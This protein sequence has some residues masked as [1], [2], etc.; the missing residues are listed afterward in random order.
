MEK[1]DPS[2]VTVRL[3]VEPTHHAIELKPIESQRTIASSDSSDS[4]TSLTTA[5]TTTASFSSTA[6]PQPAPTPS[7]QNTTPTQTPPLPA[8]NLKKFKASSVSV[9]KKFLSQSTT[10]DGKLAKNQYSASPR[11]SSLTS[12]S[13][14]GTPGSA[15]RLLT[16]KIGLNNSILNSSGAP[17][18]GWARTALLT[19]APLSLT[20]SKSPELSHP[21]AP[22]LNPSHSIDSPPIRQDAHLTSKNP[23]NAF[24]HAHSTSPYPHTSSLKPLIPSSSSAAIP[25]PANATT[26]STTTAAAVPSSSSSPSPS[27]TVPATATMAIAVSS[28]SSSATSSTTIAA[29]SSPSLPSASP[30]VKL[31]NSMRGGINSLATDFPTAQEV[32]QHTKLK[33]QS[34]AAAVA[35]RDKVVQDRAAA[36]AAYNQQL[37]QTLDGFRGTHLDPNASHWDEMEDEDDMFGEVVEFG[38]GTQYKVTEVVAPA[39]DSG[40]SLGNETAPSSG[41]SQALN[42]KNRFPEDSRRTH[43]SSTE[44]TD[45][46]PPF[47]R[48]RAELK[49]L[50]N[51]RIGKFEPY[52]GKPNEKTRDNNHPQV[53]L[54]QRQRDEPN[55]TSSSTHYSNRL[56]HSTAPDIKSTDTKLIQ[57]HRLPTHQS[58]SNK[59]IPPSRTAL[60]QPLS[61]TTLPHTSAPSS[62]S[63]PIKPA[64]NTPQLVDGQPLD[65]DT[66]NQLLR[67]KKPDLDQVHRIEMTS[68]AERARKRRQE[69]EAA[70]ESEKERAKLKATE[71]EAKLKAAAEAARVA[72]EAAKAAQDAAKAAEKAASLDAKTKN[73]SK[74]DLSPKLLQRPSSL[75]QSRNSHPTRSDSKDS[76]RRP[77]SHQTENTRAPA[78]TSQK[79]IPPEAEAAVAKAKAATGPLTTTSEVSPN[80]LTTKISHPSDN[81]RP[82]APLPSQKEAFKRAAEDMS[83]RPL[84]WKSKMVSASASQ[85]KAEDGQSQPPPPPPPSDHPSKTITIQ[86]RS[87]PPTP[88]TEPRWR[89]AQVTTPNSVSRADARQLPTHIQSDLIKVPQSTPAPSAASPQSEARST[90]KPSSDSRASPSVPLP[91][92]G[93]PHPSAAFPRSL[94]ADKKAGFKLPEMSHLDTVM[95]RIKGVLEAD[96]EARAKASIVSTPLKQSVDSRPTSVSSL[97][98]P[99]DASIPASTK[100]RPDHQSQETPISATSL[101]GQTSSSPTAVY[102]AGRPHT[103]L[104]RQ[105]ETPTILNTSSESKVPSHSALPAPGSSSTPSG[106]PRIPNT[107]SLTP[108]LTNPA[109]KKASTVRKAARFDIPTSVE[110]KPS[111][112]STSTSYPTAAPKWVK[113]DPIVF[114]DATR[115]ERPLSPRPA[116]KAFSVKFGS[117]K[118]KPRLASHVIKSFWN[119]LAPT[120]VNVLSWDP[121]MPNLSPRTLSRDDLL[122]PKKYIR[123]IVVSHVQLPKNSISN[124]VFKAPS[125]PKAP[126]SE[127]ST[128]HDGSTRGGRGRGA[129]AVGSRGRGRGRA[130]ET[131]SWRRSVEQDKTS[132]EIDVSVPS[133]QAASSPTPTCPADSPQSTTAQ[134]DPAKAGES[135]P[136]RRTK[137]KIPDGLKVAFHKP[138]HLL[139][140]TATPSGMF[141]VN[142]EITGQDVPSSQDPAP[143]SSQRKSPSPNRSPTQTSI[144]APLTP[145]VV[146][147]PRSSSKPCMSGSKGST[148]PWNKSPLAFSVLDSHT[149]NVWSQPDGQITG[150]P[151]PIGKAENSLE[152]IADDFPATLPRTLNDFNAEEEPSSSTSHQPAQYSS[153]SAR[154][155]SELTGSGGKREPNG[156]SPHNLQLGSSNYSDDHQPKANGLSGQHQYTNSPGGP[157]QYNNDASSSSNSGHMYSHHGYSSP[158]NFQVPPGYQLVPIGSLQSTQPTQQYPSIAG[159]YPGQPAS[160]PWSPS[161]GPIQPNGYARS[162]QL[163]S[164]NTSYPSPL[165]SSSYPSHAHS[166]GLNTISDGPGFNK[167]P[168][169]IAPRGSR[170]SVPT[171]SHLVNRQP[172][173]LSNF[174]PNSHPRNHPHYAPSSAKAQ[175]APGHNYHPSASSLDGP[176]SQHPSVSNTPTPAGGAGP[177]SYVDGSF[178]PFHPAAGL[179]PLVHLPPPTSFNQGAHHA[180]GAGGQANHLVG[181]HHPHHPHA[182]STLMGGPP[183][184]HYMAHGH[185]F[186]PSHGH[187]P[188]PPGSVPHGAGNGGLR[189]PGTADLLH[190]GL[191]YPQPANAAPAPP[192]HPHLH[193]HHSQGP[194]GF[195]QPPRPFHSHPAAS[196]NSGRTPAAN[197]GP[198]QPNAPALASPNS[199]STAPFS[200]YPQRR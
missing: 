85:V 180:S 160:A 78:M 38:D 14:P 125:V 41:I 112:V 36:S 142:S 137:V 82:A 57:A 130:D 143:P 194:N 175:A 122:F 30:W 64:D 129:A 138:A 42:H 2:A 44:E 79:S 127:L 34:M 165:T 144:P 98:K 74:S 81:P 52:P 31:G 149:K 185:P 94:P 121:P 126:S 9:N 33:A 45:G 23:I 65:P 140:S 99:K 147:P 198:P 174:P 91:V 39:A 27:A 193:P 95:S 161:P 16:G 69:E 90:S 12:S 96:K 5:A 21:T 62:Q 35:A 11:L 157:P 115:Q 178:G 123:G 83:N 197:P 68:A 15:P 3:T 173:E 117:G 76:W 154:K 43:P 135:Q 50:F 109:L 159:I 87:T 84:V 80:S 20:S 48:A 106:P 199:A 146:T 17:G 29:S 148:S 183:P 184:P 89:P 75:D 181:P 136:G 6:D 188:T 186:H 153:S 145:P 108:A 162:P 141:M 72:A 156:G 119:P 152:G 164:P 59:F 128:R 132:L 167:S 176:S 92:H 86:K 131:T 120:K 163:Y 54:L 26:T 47:L 177:G 66:A 114:F 100:Q 32:A 105:I 116:W 134:S 70:R 124:L 151:P 113:R 22:N 169:P 37:L 179:P 18:S 150:Q 168:G 60:S 49:S 40:P 110:S 25:S 73:S 172:N 158:S 133:E 196:P 8:V 51:E 118:P 171:A 46:M 53:Q 61:H 187:V 170:A 7:P 4:S 93:S 71:I 10:N 88:A 19:S 13:N 101:P 200:G 182:Q 77:P 189:G 111:A 63:A 58:D 191:A 139:A 166:A 190:P 55:D 155:S 103:L 1:S 28:S 56:P 192:H 24:L 97:T 102:I 107:P 104:P 195:A 67:Y